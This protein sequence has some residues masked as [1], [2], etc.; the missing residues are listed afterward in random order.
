M[1]AAP[2]GA[3]SDRAPKYFNHQTGAEHVSAI[4]RAKIGEDLRWKKGLVIQKSA[5]HGSSNL[6]RSP[7]GAAVTDTVRI[8]NDL[9]SE[10]QNKT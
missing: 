10:M 4:R 8:I 9:S 6:R 7:Q 3:G 5:V 2:S 1:K